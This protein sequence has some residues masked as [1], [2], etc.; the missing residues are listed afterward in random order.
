MKLRKT[1]IGASSG[2]PSRRQDRG[3]V[4]GECSLDT[5][6]AQLRSTRDYR[7]KTGQTAMLPTVPG[8]DHRS[9]VGVMLKRSIHL[10]IKTLERRDVPI[11][12][13]LGTAVVIGKR[14]LR[15]G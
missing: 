7:T 6:E 11:Y 13:L 14:G 5:H 4:G 9:L 1:Y 8:Q 3:V 2:R 10:R 15:L 12:A